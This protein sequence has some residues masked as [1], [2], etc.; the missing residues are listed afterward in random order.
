M[1]SHHLFLHRFPAEHWI[2]PKRFAHLPGE[3]VKGL[4]VSDCLAHY[5][6]FDYPDLN[7]LGAYGFRYS[8]SMRI[9][10]TSTRSC[11]GIMPTAQLRVVEGWQGE[12]RDGYEPVAFCADQRGRTLSKELPKIKPMRFH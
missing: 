2:A 12:M 1:T 9:S 5:D 7:G 11:L 3:R 4:I 10:G 8:D 6:E